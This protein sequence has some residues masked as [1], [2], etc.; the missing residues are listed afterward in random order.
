MRPVAIVVNATAL[1][2]SG[3]LAVLRQFIAAIPSDTQWEWVVWVSD[4]IELSASQPNVRIV[5]I[6]GVKSFVRRFWWDAYG[7][8]RWLKKRRIVPAASLSL[9]NTNF[10]TG[11]TV[12]NFVY[13]HQSI[14]FCNQ[15]WSPFH[16]QER[17]LW[18]YKT[19]YPFFVRLF[20]NRR[21][22]VFVQ[23]EYVKDGF[24]EKFNFARSKI[25][26][27]APAVLLPQSDQITPR[28]LSS[29]SINL[30]YP[31][32]GFFYKNHSTIFTALNRTKRD[33]FALYLTLTQN[34]LHLAERVEGV[35]YM[36]AL[37][38]SEVLSMYAGVDALVFPS[39]IETYGLPLIEAAA[40]GLPILAADLPYAREVLRGYRGVEYIAPFDPQAWAEAFDRIVP[41]RRFAPFVPQLKDSW[42]EMIKIITKQ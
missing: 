26:T 41:N 25:H 13:Y 22:E 19:I 14:P 5:P 42:A 29:E 35:H 32:T 16:R 18:F 10:R 36:G 12:P 23:L 34:D 38:F 39:Y 20:L 28:T 2:A 24:A 6:P 7:V 30:F 33:N 21:T 8:R 4:R 31:A 9:Q 40:L 37:P 17:A 27:I 15:R 3:A 1:D 11:Y